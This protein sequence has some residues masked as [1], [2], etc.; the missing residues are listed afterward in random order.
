MQAQAERRCRRQVVGGG[1]AISFCDAHQTA[2]RRATPVNRWR[3]MSRAE[4][5][6][7]RAASRCAG[8]SSLVW[9]QT[10]R[11]LISARYDD[12]DRDPSGGPGGFAARRQRIPH[13]SCVVRVRLHLRTVPHGRVLSHVGSRPGDSAPSSS[14]CRGPGWSRR[15]PAERP[16]DAPSPP[17]PVVNRWGSL[18]VA[19][20]AAK[21]GGPGPDDLPGRGLPPA[22][23]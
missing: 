2:V 16:G 9:V 13:G 10:T 22:V 12:L 15:S 20:R 1:L 18:P 6:F 4:R 5:S 14:S 17:R 21:P 8:R 3:C 7:C 19:G 23:W 11:S